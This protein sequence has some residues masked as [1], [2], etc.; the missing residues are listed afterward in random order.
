MYLGLNIIHNSFSNYEK[1]DKLLI[2]AGYS[3]RSKYSNNQEIS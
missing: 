1:A 3:W 2:L